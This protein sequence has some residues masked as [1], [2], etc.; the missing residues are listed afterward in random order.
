MKWK[1]IIPFFFIQISL[2]ASQTQDDIDKLRADLLRNYSKFSRGNHNQS[3]STI[4]DPEFTLVNINEFDE[5]TG[6]FTAVGFF[7]VFWTDDRLVWNAS[8]YGG[9]DRVIFFETHVWT[10][11]IVIANSNGNEESNI[12]GHERVPVVALSNGTVIW[13]PG[14]HFKTFC[15]PNVQKFPY[16]NQICEFW[17]IPWGYSS[18]DV[19][20]SPSTQKV[21]LNLYS[22]NS[23]WKMIDTYLVASTQNP[24]NN[25]EFQML[26][27]YFHLKRR[28]TFYVINMVLP[29]MVMGF[30]NL[31]VFLLPPQ[32]GERV[33][34][35]IT[36][37]L[38]ISVFLT[39]A[40]D[41]LPRNSYPAV[42]S[43]CI[44]LLMDFIISSM[45][46]LFTILG[47]RFYNKGKDKP[48]PSYIEKVARIILCRC[49][50]RKVADVTDDGKYCN[51]V[52]EFK[53]N[54]NEIILHCSDTEKFAWEDAGKAS[55]IVFFSICFL[56]FIASHLT[57]YIG[58]YNQSE[59][60]EI[61]TNFF[62]ININDFDEIE[63]TFSANGFLHIVWKDE[64]LVW[65]KTLYG[66]IE[67]IFLPQNKVWKPPIVLGNS[68]SHLQTSFVGS[69][70]MH[71]SIDI[72][73][74]IIWF[75]G[76][77]FQTFCSPNIEKFPRDIQTCELWF[78]PWI[79]T[80]NEI[81][82]KTD[83]NTADL[84]FYKENGIWKLMDTSL[85]TGIREVDHVQTQV[86]K[87]IFQLKRR[88]SFYVVNMIMPIVVLG[89]LN[90]LVFFLP[91]QSG[92]RMGYSI[93]VLLSIG[94]FLTITADSLPK[95]SYP[96]V[97]S[98]SVKLLI[99]ICISSV[100][101]LFTVIG[102]RFYHKGNTSHDVPLYLAVIAKTILRKGKAGK[103]SDIQTVKI[104]NVQEKTTDLLEIRKDSSISDLVDAHETQKDL[105]ITWEDIGKTSDIIFFT[106]SF[107]AIFISHFS[108]FSRFI[109]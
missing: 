23:V 38:A 27:I 46:V 68:N 56:G 2:T 83:A 69:P 64:R 33:G 105:Q 79:Q 87:V 85:W 96:A 67:N 103:I 60:I 30:L 5:I 102:L 81:S 104:S 82:L 76:G 31:L 37:L 92:E 8:D 88:A 48:V 47:L 61:R 97:S 13:L 89:F 42:S 16:D 98:M 78:H 20:F 10:P 14:K 106:I 63:G 57:F 91:P 77:H 93:T 51:E 15:S 6:T 71:V 36:V 66:G 73:G 101:V 86:L 28:A 72:H 75:P 1:I 21:N 52:K 19:I 18:K 44:K 65:N 25:F 34:Y 108:F 26:K 32:S 24:D 17:F 100:V 11:N 35:S 58:K 50:R 54:D 55:D 45:V 109:E 7:R 107:M 84:R 53:E 80:I 49:R 3:A 94:V 43:L 4:L 62:P 9:I 74:T 12:L 41:N 59:P 70:E 40:S 95:S 90:L 39:I 29:I 99:D 22:N